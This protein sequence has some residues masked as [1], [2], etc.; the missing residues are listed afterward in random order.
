MATSSINKKF[1]INNG[2]VAD[3]FFQDLSNPQII[4]VKKNDFSEDAVKGAELFKR[5]LNR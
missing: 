3:R 1:V 2:E 5:W 4:N